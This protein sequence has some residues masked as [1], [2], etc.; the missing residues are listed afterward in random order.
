[1]LNFNENQITS[2]PSEVLTGCRA[3]HT[4]L[5]HSNP[6]TAQVNISCFRLSSHPDP[7]LRSAFHMLELFNSSVDLV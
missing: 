2:V 1:M 4:L 7:L 6:I 3:L 5:L